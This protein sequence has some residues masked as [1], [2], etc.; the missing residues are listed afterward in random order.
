M[1]TLMP[2]PMVNIQALKDLVAVGN[3]GL[4]NKDYGRDPNHNEEPTNVGLAFT[5]PNSSLTGAVLNDM[6]KA[7]KILIILVQ[8]FTYKMVLL[9]IMSGLV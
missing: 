2:V 3:V 9:G 6:L 7:I 1:Y 4:I 5:T 8:I